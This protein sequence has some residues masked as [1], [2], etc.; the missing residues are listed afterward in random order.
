MIEELAPAHGLTPAQVPIQIIG[1]KLGEKLYEELMNDEE[2]RRTLELD[3]YFVVQPGFKPVYET[4]EY[5]YPNMTHRA[6]DRPYN[7]ALESAMARAD[8]RRYLLEN[9]LI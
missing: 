2:T 5:A 1:T 8:L 4:I 3:K 6:V 9:H 7:S